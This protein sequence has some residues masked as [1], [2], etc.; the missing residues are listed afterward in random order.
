MLLDLRKRLLMALVLANVGRIDFRQP[1]LRPGLDHKLL[2][3]VHPGCSHY[4]E[5]LQ[6]N[7]KPASMFAVSR[8]SCKTDTRCGPLPAP[9]ATRT[10]GRGSHL[11]I[12]LGILDALPLSVALECLT[13]NVSR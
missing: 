12:F 11:A 3:I 4:A 1:N 6:M 9:R 2:S 8:P 7:P 13:S 10:L 5:I